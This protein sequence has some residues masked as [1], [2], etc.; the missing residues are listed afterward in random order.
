MIRIFRGIQTWP[1]FARNIYGLFF[2]D[3]PVAFS[4]FSQK[5]YT[6]PALGAGIR[7]QLEAFIPLTLGLDFHYGT[8]SSWAGGA[9]GIFSVSGAIP[10]L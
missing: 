5:W 6:L 8:E 3:L 7:L 10:G 1:V 4:D 9:S 2:F